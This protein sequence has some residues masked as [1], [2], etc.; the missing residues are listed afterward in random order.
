MNQT[1]FIYQPNNDGT[2]FAIK[3]HVTWFG[4]ILTSLRQELG[5]IH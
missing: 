2:K 4:L 3:L 1:M 5:Y